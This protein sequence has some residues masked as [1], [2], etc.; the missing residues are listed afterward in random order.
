MSKTAASLRALSRRTWI[1]PVILGAV[2]LIVGVATTSVSSAA[3][4][5]LPTLR[6]ALDGRSVRV[7]GALQS[8][9][10]DVVSSVSVKH[11]EPVLIRLNPGVP[12]SAF[13]QA[14]AAINTHHGDLNYLDPYGSI[15]FDVSADQGTTAAQTSL[16]PGNYVAVDISS[17]NPNPPLATFVIGAAAA[18]PRSLPRPGATISAIDFGFRGPSTLHDGELVRFQNSGFLVHPLQ[19]IGVTSARNARRLT[20]LL[21]AANDREAPKLGI[22]F[23]EFAGPLSPGGAQQELINERPGL[24]VLASILRTQDGREQTQLGMVRTIRIVK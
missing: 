16:Q 7:S 22:S 9:A 1:G 15:V 19:G 13:A 24:Y 6:L 8:G 12:F 2:A 18:Q 11:T 23:P 5:G 17:S 21:R 10:V 20:A 3:S 4:S 14:A